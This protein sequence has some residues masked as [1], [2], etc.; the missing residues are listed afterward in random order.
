M[1]K[2]LQPEFDYSAWMLMPQV[3][4]Q[5]AMASH[6]KYTPLSCWPPCR[7]QPT[8][9]TIASCVSVFER[10]VYLK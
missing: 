5:G 2:N 7:G 4:C 6:M 9:A 8:A 1:H 10:Q 3:G